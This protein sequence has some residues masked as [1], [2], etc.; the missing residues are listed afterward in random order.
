MYMDIVLVGPE[1]SGNIG[2]VAR[3]MKNFSFSRLIL[4]DPRCEYD[5]EEARNRAKHANDIIDNIRIVHS[6][7]EIEHDYRIGTT[8]KL[9][10][11]Y[12]LSRTPSYPEKLSEMIGEIEEGRKDSIG[13]YFGRESHGLTNE[14]ISKMD[15]N[16]HIPTDERYSSLNLSHSV[17]II[18]YELSKSDLTLKRNERYKPMSSRE[19]MIIEELFSSILDKLDFETETK[20][21]TQDTLWKR[22]VGKSMLTMRESYALMGLLRKIHERIKGDDDGSP[23]K[24]KE[25]QED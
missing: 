17:G 5:N 6:I 18:L 25:I 23:E 14:E 19:K 21:K 4:V 16:V 9:G 8:A 1:I 22:M 20:R 10:S 13:I 15:F 11:D 2:A 24:K 3:V 7:N 12:N